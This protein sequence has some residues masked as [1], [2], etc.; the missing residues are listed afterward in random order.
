[1]ALLKL[2]QKVKCT[3]SCKNQSEGN[4]PPSL[5]RIRGPLYCT[6]DIAIP[7]GAPPPS[8]SVVNDTQETCKPDSVLAYS[9]HTWMFFVN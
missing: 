3:A 4:F 7:Q 1:M 9:I 2:A 5:K 8:V 6:Q